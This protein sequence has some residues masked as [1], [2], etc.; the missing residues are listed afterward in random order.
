[1]VARIKNAIE[2]KDIALEAFLDIERAFD[3]TSFDTIKQ[4]AERHCTDHAIC[5][6]ICAMLESKNIIATLSGET[7][8]APVARGCLQGSVLS[9]RLWGLAVVDLLWEL[10]DGGYYTVGY[11]DDIAILINGKFPQTVSEVLQSALCTVNQWCEGMKL[12][13]DPNKTVVIRFTKKRNVKGLK[14]P[15]LFN[16]RFQLSRD[17][18][19]LGITFDVGQTWKMQLDKF[20]NKAYKAFWTCRDTFGKTWGL[21]PKVMYWIYTAV[22]RLMFTYAG[23]ELNSREVRPNLANC[24][25]WPAWE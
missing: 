14:K 11:A 12:S 4:A 15:T 24:K 2:H 19:Y 20:I 13:I 1:V 23:L 8:G 3:S 10:N 5:R 18:T 6:R 22:V 7:L 21:K 25:G 9:P 16:K 17:V